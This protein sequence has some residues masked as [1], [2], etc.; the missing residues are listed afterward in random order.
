MYLFKPIDI[1]IIFPKIFNMKWNDGKELKMGEKSLNE[2]FLESETM[3]V[4]IENMNQI[5]H[6]KYCDNFCQN[7]LEIKNI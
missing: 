6:G 4:L 7:I 5:N 3:N 1:K 2:I